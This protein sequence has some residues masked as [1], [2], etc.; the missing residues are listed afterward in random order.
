MSSNTLLARYPAPN[1]PSPVAAVIVP[2][3][4]K[5]VSSPVFGETVGSV[6]LVGSSFLGSVGLTVGVVGS[7]TF[8]L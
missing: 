8:V 4:A 5:L 3:N 7:S 1:N 6:G 2:S